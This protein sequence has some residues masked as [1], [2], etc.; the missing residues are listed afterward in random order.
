MTG[1]D[2]VWRMEVEGD[3]TPWQRRQGSGRTAKKPARSRAWQE[4][5]AM[6]WLAQAGHSFGR[7]EVAVRVEVWRRTRQRC[8]VDNLAKQVLDGLNGVAWDD[9]SQVCDLHVTR[10]YDRARPRVVVEVRAWVD[11]G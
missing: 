2:R 10:R 4:L 8:D 11:S 5:L 7:G 9:D 3:L 6:S 1:S